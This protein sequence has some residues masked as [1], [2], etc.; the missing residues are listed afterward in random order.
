LDADGNLGSAV[1]EIWLPGVAEFWGSEAYTGN[2]AYAHPNG[3]TQLW[4]ADF[5][6]KHQLVLDELLHGFGEIAIAIANTNAGTCTEPK[7]EQIVYA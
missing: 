5:A 2:D 3:D 6:M 7:A 1:M 4:L